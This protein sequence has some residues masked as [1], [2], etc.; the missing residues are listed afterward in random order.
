MNHG[1]PCTMALHMVY[2]SSRQYNILCRL[3]TKLPKE[4]VMPQDQDR[5]GN[6]ASPAN[7][8]NPGGPH[9]P[10]DP[11]TPATPPANPGKRP[12]PRPDPGGGRRVG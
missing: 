12:H 5:P 4:K 8:A 1:L 7:P 3:K 10:A 9:N 6:P 2:G 11:A